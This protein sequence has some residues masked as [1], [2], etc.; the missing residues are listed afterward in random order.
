MN[1][2]TKQIL[3]SMTC[4]MIEKARCQL[5][6]NLSVDSASLLL[7]EAIRLTE[8]V[9]PNIKPNFIRDRNHIIYG[10]HYDFLHQFIG[11]LISEIRRDLSRV[12]F[13]VE[14]SLELTQEAIHLLSLT[15]D[16]NDYNEEEN[17]EL[18]T[19]Q[20]S[21]SNA[22]IIARDLERSLQRSGINRIKKH[23]K[24]MRKLEQVLQ[25]IHSCEFNLT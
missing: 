7:Q 8:E 22:K 2:K 10:D 9:N 3:H 16:Y 21:L 1:D 25:E 17:E 13:S 6:A 14:T 11:N 20:I 12:D 15:N 24:M 19:G 23:L 4:A 5:A 18:N